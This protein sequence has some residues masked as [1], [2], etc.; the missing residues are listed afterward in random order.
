MT[1]K[2]LATNVEIQGDIRISIWDDMGESETEIHEFSQVDS[3]SGTL[4]KPAFHYLR[5]LQVTYM[6]APGD[7]FLHIELKQK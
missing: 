7:G 3:L 2:S 6:F 1:L 4:S 5:N